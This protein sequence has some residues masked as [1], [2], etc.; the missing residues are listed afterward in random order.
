[1]KKLIAIILSLLSLLSLSIPACAATTVSLSWCNAIAD[2]ETGVVYIR[3]ST[4]D[5]SSVLATLAFGTE[6]QVKA[7][8]G[9]MQW[10]RPSTTVLPDIVVR[11]LSAPAMKKLPGSVPPLFAAVSSVNLLQT[12][13][14]L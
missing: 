4:S 1:M 11:P 2:N 8:T 13:S 5:S 12:C 6:L 9:S 10:F 7:D 3:S 14:A